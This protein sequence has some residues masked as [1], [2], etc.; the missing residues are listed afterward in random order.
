MTESGR[1]RAAGLRV[2]AARLAVLE[3]VR[4]AGHP[5]T[6]GIAC[7][8]RDRAGHVTLRAGYEAL[9]ALTAAGAGAPDRAGGQPGPVRARVG[10]SHHHL[11]CRGCGD[12]AD[13]DC[14]AGPALC[15][16]PA[17]DAGFAA[18]GAE[19]RSGAVPPLPGRP[20]APGDQ[21]GPGCVHCGHP[22]LSVRRIEHDR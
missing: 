1:L 5:G 3:T 9:N 18:A 20:A 4:A 10:D 8:A 11:V 6:G 22:E 19:A 17:A 21:P 14:M 2:T 7:A 15:R 12:V 13:V 16:E